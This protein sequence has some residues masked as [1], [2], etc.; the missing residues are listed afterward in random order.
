MS[1]RTPA[2]AES[3]RKRYARA[4]RIGDHYLAASIER[5]W[6]LYGYAPETVSTVLA[7]VS[8]GL[9]LDA[10]IDEATGEQP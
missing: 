9:L 3:D 10:A 2:Q 8:T 1:E 4:L 6:G 7:C 5:R